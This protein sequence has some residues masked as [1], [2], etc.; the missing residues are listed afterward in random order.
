MSWLL[1]SI[2][3]ALSPQYMMDSAK[4]IWDSIAQQFS[5]G[6]NYAQ[7]Y[8]ISKQARQM[9]QGGC[10]LLLITLL[11]FTS[12]SSLILIVLISPLL[13]RNRLL[14][15]GIQGMREFMSFSLALILSL[16]IFGFKFLVECRFPHY[17]KPIKCFSMRRLVAVL[18]C[19]L[20]LL[21]VLLLSQCLGHLFLSLILSTTVHLFLNEPYFQTSLQ[22]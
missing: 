8:E 19:L 11:S 9:R 3:L 6:N 2:E 12:G 7:A 16:I 18:C 14:I 21:I 20:A 13:L 15:R 1:N 4:D 5:Q 22:G 10:L 17:E